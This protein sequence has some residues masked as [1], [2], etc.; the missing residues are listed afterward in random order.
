NKRAG[1]DVPIS[2][3]I[4]LAFTASVWAT[5]TDEGHI[6]YDSVVMFVFFLLGARYLELVARKRGSDQVDELAHATPSDA[7]RLDVVDG[8]RIE[9]VVPAVELKAGDLVLVRPGET[10]PV[11]GEIVEGSS[12]VDESLWTGE[13]VPETRNVGQEVI[14]GSVNIESPLVLRVTKTGSDTVLA[15]VERLLERAQSEKPKLARAADKIAGWFVGAVLCLAAATAVFWWIAGNDQW[16]PIT[17]AVLV[18]S[19]PCALSL[20]TPTAITAATHNL[21]HQG[22]LVTRADALESLARATH[23]V[24]DKTGTLTKGRLR[25]SAVHPFASKSEAECTRIAASLERFSEHPIAKALTSDVTNS[26][27]SEVS[28]VRNIPGQG[29]CGVIEGEFVVIG[30]ARYVREQTGWSVPEPTL[31]ELERTGSM[32]VLLANRKGLLCGFCLEDTVRSE[33]ADLVRSLKDAGKVVMLLTGDRMAAAHCLGQKLGI[34]EIY[35]NM[36]PEK[37][38]E[39]V[40]ELHRG[41]ATVAMI[42]DGVNDAPVLG[43]AQVSAAV[44]GAAPLAEAAADL[45]LLKKNLLDFKHAIVVSSRTFNVIRQNLTWALCYNIVAIPVAALGYLAPWLAALGMSL[46]SVV[47]VMNALRLRQCRAKAMGV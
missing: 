2:L 15:H 29:M 9:T 23:F 30:N 37:K 32:V 34:S 20:A 25:I 11:D 42:G 17:I 10:V 7:T 22:V 18:V 4:L 41:G 13:S 21:L 14:G 6:Y 8:G 24:F 19:C 28:E 12:T 40:K 3:G 46:S 26:D 1:M 16:L 36:T 27:I 31:Q 45:V 39:K 43:Q 35:V 5:V 44:A 38:L 47:V 33:S